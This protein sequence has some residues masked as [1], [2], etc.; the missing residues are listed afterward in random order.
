V[1]HIQVSVVVATIGRSGAL[2]RC[3]EAVLE[4]TLAP[5]EIIVVDQ[6]GA[7]EIARLLDEERRGTSTLHRIVQPRRGLS[8]ARNAGARAAAGD[9]IAFTD[10]DCVPARQWVEA[11][12]AAFVANPSFAAVTGPMLPLPGGPDTFAVSSRTSTVRRFFSRRA[13][14]WEIG[15]GGNTAVRR[16]WLERLGGYDER[17]G[18]GTARRAGEDLDLFRRLLEIGGSIVYHP[19]AVC[20]HERKTASERRARRY[21]YGVGA[22]AALGRWLRDGDPRAT[23]ALAH[24]IALRARSTLQPAGERT[25]SADELRVLIGTLVG[26][27]KGAA[28]KPW[29][30]GART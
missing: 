25:S 14:P 10:D 7:R 24:W 23:L 11:L 5:A 15:T 20:R 27:A 3:L 13:L 28:L 21:A 30:P 1:S 26:F 9:V 19:A 12:V 8:A 22:G 17:L 16:E 18:V 4:G 6:S 29:K 2:G